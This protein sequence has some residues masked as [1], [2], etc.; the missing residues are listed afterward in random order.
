MLLAIA[1]CTDASRVD[2]AAHLPSRI[3]PTM[4]RVTVTDGAR[5]STWTGADLAGMPS[6][7]ASR[8]T[9]TFGQLGYGFELRD[10]LGM[11]I[12][13]GTLALPLR[14][15]WDWGIDLFVQATNPAW[16]CFGCSGAR[17]FPLAAPYQTTPQ[18]SVWLAWGGNSIRHPVTY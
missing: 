4:L 13:S 5:S 12:S 8:E 2:V 15:D 9:R 1:A 10:S 11:L 18:D 3:A 6:G 14:S 7:R 17:A 16:S